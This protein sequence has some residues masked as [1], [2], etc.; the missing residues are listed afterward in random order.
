MSFTLDKVVHFGVGIL[1][2]LAS[3]FYFYL[4]PW[5]W[6]AA[7]SLWAVPVYWETNNPWKESKRFKDLTGEDWAD[8]IWGWGGMLIGVILVLAAIQ[9]F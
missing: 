8:I 3:A 1:L 9:S 4:S 6:L 5:T 7:A 2:G